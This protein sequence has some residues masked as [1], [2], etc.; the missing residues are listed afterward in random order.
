MTLAWFR[1]AVPSPTSPL[2]DT[3]PVIDGL[4][5]RQHEVHVITDPLEADARQRSHAPPDL[6]VF[7]IDD[8]PAHAWIRGL[9][10]KTR[11]VVLLKSLRSRDSRAV[12][13]AALLTVVS[14]PAVAEDLCTAC[15]GIPVRVT[16]TGVRR[17]PGAPVRT[18]H[19]SG[20]VLGLFPAARADLVQRVLLRSGLAD[21]QVA[22]L[23]GPSPEHVLLGSNVVLALRWP[24]Y[25]EPPTDA[26]AGMASGRAV[27][28][29]ETAGTA[30]WPA[31]DPQ[32]WRPRGPGTDPPIAVSI[33]PLD[34]EH[35]L[36]L[37]LTRLVSDP[38]LRVRLGAAAF[39]WWNAHATPAHAVDD[40]E[41][42]LRET[43][44][45]TMSPGEARAPTNS[46]APS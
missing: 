31:L 11:G 41:R 43:R 37:T 7:E 10:R 39:D 42:V 22:L 25:G 21:H 23:T 1:P 32:T 14:H 27:V 45:R 2:D 26:L 8:D 4:R 19:G 40:W 15:P 12:A 6:A 9:A 5:S 24:W 34:E 13:Q 38:A 17:L 44:E 16:T 30:D 29:L 33:D 18:D 28:V 46:P 3:A 36:T 20:V 35:S